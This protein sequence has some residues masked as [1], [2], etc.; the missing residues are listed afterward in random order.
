MGAYVLKERERTPR[1]TSP[2]AWAVSQ[3]EPTMNAL[4]AITR[5][6]RL[7]LQAGYHLPGALALKISGAAAL[8]SACGY[9]FHKW[10]RLSHIPGPFWT[11]YPFFRLLSRGRIYEDFPALNKKYGKPP[12]VI[13]S[14]LVCAWQRVICS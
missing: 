1:A 10:Y 7:L 3:I 14:L 4:T 9:A 2:R 6:A 8:L 12:L 13:P 5:C 11:P